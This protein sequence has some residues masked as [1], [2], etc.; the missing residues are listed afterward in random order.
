MATF[1]VPRPPDDHPWQGGLKSRFPYQI[2][3]SS[4]TPPFPAK[5]WRYDYDD[6]AF[7]VRKS[8]PLAPL[9]LPAGGGIPFK[10]PYWKFHYDDSAYWVNKSVSIPPVQFPLN[11]GIPIKPPYWKYNYDDPGF[12]VGARTVPVFQPNLAGNFIV[13]TGQLPLPVNCVLIGDQVYQTGRTFEG[14]ATKLTVKPRMWT[15]KK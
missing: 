12:W 1:Y 10:P 7:W 4:Q 13:T 6:A 14:G 15:P 3:V 11:G 2:F 9:R 5:F 8:L